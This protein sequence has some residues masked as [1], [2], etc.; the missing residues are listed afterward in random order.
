MIIEKFSAYILA[1]GKSRRLGVNKLYVRID[2]RSLLERTIAVCKAC[3]ATAKLVAGSS[4]GLSVLD[5]DIV[6]DSPLARGPMAGVIAALE[7]CCSDYCFVTA[8]DLPDLSTELI[9]MLT[10]RCRDFQYIGVLEENGLQPLCGIYHASSLPILMKAASRKEYSL[11]RTMQF[12]R[13]GGVIPCGEQWRNINR[14]QDLAVG[15]IH[16]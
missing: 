1:G 5:C 11:N 8:A 14:P 15:D 13:H 3:F 4:N 2:G 6:A 16:V 9:E 12:L 10:T 7:D